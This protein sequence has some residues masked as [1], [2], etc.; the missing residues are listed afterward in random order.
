MHDAG[1]EVKLQYLCWLPLRIDL[2]FFKL[3]G[4]FLVLQN[5]FSKSH[6]TKS[7]KDCGD[8]KWILIIA[9]I[10]LITWELAGN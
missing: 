8:I 4:G 5:E 2:F 1:W 6:N 7:T 10:L 3:W 9:L